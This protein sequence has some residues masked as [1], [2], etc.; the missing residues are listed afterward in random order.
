[1]TGERNEHVDTIEFTETH[2]VIGGGFDV[3]VASLVVKRVPVEEEVTVKLLR[4]EPL[5]LDEVLPALEYQFVL[6]V[7]LAAQLALPLPEDPQHRLGV[8]ETPHFVPRVVEIK[9]REP[10]LVGLLRSDGVHAGL[11]PEVVKLEPAVPPAEAHGELRLV[12]GE[13]GLQPR[14]AVQPHAGQD[15]QPLLAGGRQ[16]LVVARVGLHHTALQLVSR[17][18]AVGLAVTPGDTP[19]Y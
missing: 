12:G 9:G 4:V 8:G 19:Q 7:L 6:R 14:E 11:C 1:M 13:D 17:V 16:E 18:P 5:V 10:D 15:G 2:F 3:D